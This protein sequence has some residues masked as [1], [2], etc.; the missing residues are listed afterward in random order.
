M[1]M[2]ELRDILLRLSATPPWM[3]DPPNA[4]DA[5]VHPLSLFWQ[6]LWLS[7]SVA[8]MAIFVWWI[9]DKL[10]PEAMEWV[11]SIGPWWKRSIIDYQKWLR[12]HQK[13]RS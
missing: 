11:R 2:P 1:E 5:G 4:F 10:M 8:G 12:L 13:P 9:S 3:N 7:G 6:I